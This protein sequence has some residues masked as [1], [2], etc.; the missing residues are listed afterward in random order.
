MIEEKDTVLNDSSLPTE[1]EAAATQ[2][3]PEDMAADIPANGAGESA[4]DDKNGKKAAMAEIARLES[5]LEAAQR[6]LEEQKK[7]Y[8]V[9]NDKYLR[10][11][12]EY[13]NYRKRVAKERQALGNEIAADVIADILPIYDNLERAIGFSDAEKVAEGLTLIYKSFTETL[14]KLGVA[15]IEALGCPFDPNLHNAVLHVED[16]AYGENVVIDVLQ[17]GYIKG[18]RIIRHA[19]VKVAN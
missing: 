8:A 14:K 10:M 4:A 18:D 19:M 13:D 12:A 3:I 16:E 1:D 15:E 11:M 6:Q 7:A 17:K 9:L 2:A 5:A